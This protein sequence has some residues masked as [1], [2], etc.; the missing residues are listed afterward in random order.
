MS[1]VLLA[2]ASARGY[3]C[4]R[5]ESAQLTQA[6]FSI[7]F[8]GI[9][10]GPPGKVPPPKISAQV[11]KSGRVGAASL[12]ASNEGQKGIPKLLDG[13]KPLLALDR[14]RLRHPQVHPQRKVGSVLQ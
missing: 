10:Q 11:S 1:W 14:E 3:E 13:S 9:R 2:L 8:R 7:G 12:A 6:A 5:V 4:R